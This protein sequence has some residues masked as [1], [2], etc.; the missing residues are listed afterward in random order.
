MINLSFLL[1]V[2][3]TISVIAGA[4]PV[5]F[6]QSTFGTILGTVRDQSG[7]LL[8]GCVVTVENSGTS[9]RRGTVADEAGTYTAPNLEPGTYKV[10]MEMLGFQVAEYTNIQLLA[11]QTIR[12]DSQMMVASQVETVSVTA[13]AAPVIN[14]EVS[15]IAETKTGRELVDLPIAITARSAG[16]T[17]PLSTLT[18]QPGV[19]TDSSGNISVVGT[20]PSMLSTSIDG[21]SSI[22]P[23]TSAPLAELFPSLNSIAEIRVSEVNN[24]AEFGGVS[25]ITTISKSGTNSVHG[26]LFENLQN[27]V[28]NARNPFSSIRPKTIMNNFGFFLGGPVAFPGLYKGR[29]KTF[30]FMAYEGLRL[31]KQTVVVESVPSLA[32]RNGDLSA[33]S[34]AIKDPNTGLPF[35]GN[36]IPADRIS[37]LSQNVLKYLFPLPNTGSPNAIANNYVQNF[38]TPISS[39]QADLRLDQNIN[40]RQ[41]AFARFTW[42]KRSVEAAPQQGGLVNGSA[43]LGSFS[44]PET[45]YGLTVA[46]NF[47]ITPTL[48]NE[49]RAGFTKQTTA[50]FFGTTPAD[51]AAKLG[52]T[53][54]PQPYPS[55]NAV[56]NFM[57]TGF[58]QTGGNSS[59]IGRDGTFQVLDNLTWTSSGH[60]LKFGGDFRYMT[61]FRNNVYAPQ[62]L[63]VYTFNNSVTSSLIGNPFAAFLLGVPDK[64]QLNTVIQPDSDGVAH[65]FAFYLQDDWKV[66]PRLTLNYGLRWEYHPMFWDRLLNS[67]N[68]LLD[69]SSIVNAKRVNGAVV[70]SNNEAFSI[71]NPDFAASIGPTPILTAKQAGI[72]ESLRYSEKNDFAPRV[73]FA[74]RLSGDGKAVIR[75]G[76][77][78]FIQGPLG[79]LLGAAYAIHSANQAFYNQSIVNGQPTLRFPY[80]FPANLAQPGTQFFQQ[81]GDVHYKDPKVDQWNLTVERDLGFSTALRLSYNG[82]HGSDLGRQGNADQ[83]APN[84]T[85]YAAGS[86]LL[87]YPD[88]GLMQI[89]TNGG[90]SNYHSLTGALTKRLSHGLQFQS[91]YT[92][93]RNLTNAQ[94]Y[95]PTSFASEAGGIVTDLRD[96]QID[97]GNVAFSR[98]HRFLTTAL[99]QLPF[100]RSGSALSQVIGGWE[101][102]GVLLF[103]SGPFM[104]VTVPGADPSGTGFPLLIGNGRADL[105]PGVSLY[106][107][108]KTSQ[109]WLNPAAFAVPRSNIGRYPTAPVGNVLGPGTQAISMSLTKSVRITESVRFQIGAQAANLLNHVNYAPPSTVFNTAPFGT[110]SNVQAAEGAGPRQIQI[111]SRL[112]F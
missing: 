74:W 53:G 46:H 43:L 84:T 34:A 95:N 10:K 105:V 56:P 4:A 85:G 58:Q 33:Y 79:A 110:I 75:G 89:E 28:L 50:T 96:P 99:Y 65:S 31:P 61:G 35:S 98:R 8:P 22:G 81:A 76:F 87:L 24:T 100:G 45:D 73:G 14:T 40:S 68:F 62:R 69:Y 107:G 111:T 52:L 66:T 13:E 97:Y 63:G 5:A 16:S 109:H 101:F 1:R 55:G 38:S 9:V 80:P 26:G 30:F 17:S 54:L 57:I 41:T 23:R 93:L 37:P 83:L 72:P 7:A 91:S 78:R 86:P 42:K 36:Q 90:R 82:S 106:A 112:T 59:R 88:F 19:Q 77:G 20:K 60:T 103:Q 39:N 15:N 64:T 92:Y 104:T 6:G 25:D 49:V 48:L 70:I 27:T 108:D 44:L 3:L 18:S 47:V 71:L 94:G 2:V 32:L 12:I 11:R 21:I 51:I 102:G 29:D 67:T